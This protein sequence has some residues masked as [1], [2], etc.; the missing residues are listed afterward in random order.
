MQPP[1]AGFTERG[2]EIA[3]EDGRRVQ[4]FVRPDNASYGKWIDADGHEWRIDVA[5][6]LG[7]SSAAPPLPG[8][9]YPGHLTSCTAHAPLAS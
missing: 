7:M 9:V 4:I 5:L 1:I 8:G 6:Q 3:L 2:P